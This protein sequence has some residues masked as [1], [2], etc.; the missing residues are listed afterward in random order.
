M[1]KNELCD[2]DIFLHNYCD[3]RNDTMLVGK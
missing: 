3:M 1:M 2:F